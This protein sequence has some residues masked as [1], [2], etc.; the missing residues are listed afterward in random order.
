MHE[1]NLIAHIKATSSLIDS[2]HVCIKPWPS[3]MVKSGLQMFIEVIL[4]PI[5]FL[6]LVEF[7]SICGY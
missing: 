2:R 7:A 5:E 6:F 3:W 1:G 4:D